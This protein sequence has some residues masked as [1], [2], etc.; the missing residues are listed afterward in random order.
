MLGWSLILL[1]G[2]LVAGLLATA[3]DGGA[4]L[5]LYGVF[6]GLLIASALVG[7]WRRRPPA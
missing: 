5:L 2:A 6:F 1:V 3:E 7:A 4:S